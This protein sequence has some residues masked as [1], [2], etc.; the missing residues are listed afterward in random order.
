M[1]RTIFFGKANS[2]QRK[3]YHAVLN[4]QK[5]SIEYLET[6]LK[7]KELIQAPSIDQVMRDYI[8]TQGYKPFN[9]SSHGI[10]LKVHESP[11]LWPSSKDII[12]EKM[13]F[14]N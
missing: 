10:G 8:I 11:H 4:G 2:E 9:H 5:T 12:K 13:V 3:L 6:K 14:F 1:T 7:S